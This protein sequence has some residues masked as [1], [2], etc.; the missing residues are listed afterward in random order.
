MNKLKAFFLIF[1]QRLKSIKNLKR[2]F[3]I[4]EPSIFVPWDIDETTLKS[5]FKGND[6]KY[7]TAGYYTAVCTS[8]NG[9]KCIIGFHF[10][11]RTNGKLNEFE[12]FRKDYSDRQKSFDEFQAVFVQTFGNPSSTTKGREEFNNYSWRFGNI[13]IEHYVFNRFGLEEHMHIKK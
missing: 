5:L 10:S 12:F 1:F 6:L 4:N 8:L 2:G 13:K 9:L 11:P 7:V 3:Q